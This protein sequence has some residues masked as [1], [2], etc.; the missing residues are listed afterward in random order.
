MARRYKSNAIKKEEYR[1]LHGTFGSNDSSEVTL[2]TM[3][4][5]TVRRWLGTLYRHSGAA[6]FVGWYDAPVIAIAMAKVSA[7][8]TDGIGQ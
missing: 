7:I 1:R 8:I 2:N 3:T 6:S 5:I 4:I